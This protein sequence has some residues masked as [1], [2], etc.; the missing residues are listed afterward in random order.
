[1]RIPELHA[2]QRAITRDFAAVRS[3]RRSCLTSADTDE[4]GDLGGAAF[5]FE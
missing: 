4:L 2:I 1:M 5:G 3:S